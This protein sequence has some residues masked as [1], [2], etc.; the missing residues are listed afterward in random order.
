LLEEEEELTTME[1]LHMQGVQTVMG[2]IQE[3]L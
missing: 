1:L 2:P 3:V